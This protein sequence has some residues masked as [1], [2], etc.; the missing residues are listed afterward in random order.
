MFRR[1]PAPEAMRGGYRLA[2]K[3]MRQEI[4]RVHVAILQERDMH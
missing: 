2:D 4:T 3:N 1:K